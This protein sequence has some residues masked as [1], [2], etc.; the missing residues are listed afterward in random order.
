[1]L[2][3]HSLEPVLFVQVQHLHVLEEFG[4]YEDLFAVHHEDLSDGAF[5][6]VLPK[7]L[8]GRGDMKKVA[9]A[10]G[11]FYK[12]D[13]D[14]VVECGAYFIESVEVGK[15]ELVLWEADS[16]HVDYYIILGKNLIGYVSVN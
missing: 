15:A 5:E 1:M 13:E 4:Y 16:E 11:F 10:G 7:S 12:V 14:G 3:R 2:R 6:M 9:F 8:T